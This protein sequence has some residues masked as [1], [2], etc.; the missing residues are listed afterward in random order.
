MTTIKETKKETTNKKAISPYYK[1]YYDTAPLTRDELLKTNVGY[2]K[3]HKEWND[4]TGTYKRYWKREDTPLTSVAREVRIHSKRPIEELKHESTEAYACVKNKTREIQLVINETDNTFVHKNYYPIAGDFI[5]K[6]IIEESDEKIQR[7]AWARIKAELEPINQ[8]RIDH[9][10]IWEA[11]DKDK[12]RQDHNTT[13]WASIALN[14]KIGLGINTD[15]N[16]ISDVFREVLLERASDYGITPQPIVIDSKEVYTFQAADIQEESDDTIME[17]IWAEQDREALTTPYNLERYKPRTVV[18]KRFSYW[19]YTYKKLKQFIQDYKPETV[20]DTLRNPVYSK[21]CI[22]KIDRMHRRYSNYWLRPW[23]AYH[24]PDSKDPYTTIVGRWTQTVIPTYKENEAMAIAESLKRSPYANEFIDMVEVWNTNYDVILPSFHQSK[25]MEALY[26]LVRAKPEKIQRWETD[27]VFSKVQTFYDY[28]SI[29][30]NIDYEYP[31]LVED[32]DV[33]GK[34]EDI[35][36]HTQANDFIERYNELLDVSLGEISKTTYNYKV[37][38]LQHSASTL[39]DEYAKRRERTQVI[40]NGEDLVKLVPRSELRL[41]DYEEYIVEC[42][43]YQTEVDTV[44][45]DEVD[46]YYLL[47]YDITD[48]VEPEEEDIEEA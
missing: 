10:P 45:S 46:E 4:S 17:R 19:L 2:V 18:T 8:R 36:L 23:K 43:D 14:N 44:N 9:Y 37:Q 28:S 1:Y 26:K 7:H 5:K 31:D 21:L 29:V 38:L 41:N 24:K 27:S 42:R 32:L 39:I 33:L 48:N 11:L 20:L 30:A 22:L 47:G 15:Y 6:C 16:K 12:A 3:Y 35:V 25:V 34:T 13:T 40:T